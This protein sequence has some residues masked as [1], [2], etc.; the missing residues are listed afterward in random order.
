MFAFAAVIL[1]SVL[2]AGGRLESNLSNNRMY[3]FVQ[4]EVRARSNWQIT[5][6]S[7]VFIITAVLSGFCSGLWLSHVIGQDVALAHL[8]ALRVSE[9]ALIRRPLFAQCDYRRRARQPPPIEADTPGRL[10]RDFPTG[11][12]S[13]AVVLI[14]AGFVTA[15]CAGMEVLAI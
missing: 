7:S 6:R 13:F 3:D 1:L 4:T 9:R 10:W 12:R 2:A 14:I 5:L 15:G 11:R 8:P